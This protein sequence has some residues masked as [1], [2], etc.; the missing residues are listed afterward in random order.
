MKKIY[1]ISA[2]ATTVALVG[3]GT[4]LLLTNGAA[5]D[6]AA[7]EHPPQEMVWAASVKPVKL[8]S[9]TPT[10][11]LLGRVVSFTN[12]QLSS[13]LDAAVMHVNAVEGQ[14]VEQ[15]ETLIELDPRNIETAIA[16]LQADADRVEALLK[17][18]RIKL[19]TNREA[20]IYATNLMHLATESR[21]RIALLRQRN[22]ADLAVFS[23]ALIDE[24]NAKLAVT[25]RKALIREHGSHVARLQADLRHISVSLRNAEADLEESIIKAPIAGR[26]TAVH[27]A[28]GEQVRNGSPILDMFDHQA[29]EIRSLIPTRHLADVKSRIS[30]TEKPEAYAF[31]DNRRLALKLDRLSASVEQGRGGVEAFFQIEDSSFYPELGRTV[32]VSLLQSPVDNA[33]AIPSQT[34]YGAD[35]VFKL[36]DGRLKSVPISRHGEIFRNGEWLVIAVSDQLQA[37]DLIITSRLDNPVDGGKVDIAASAD[38]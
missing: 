24:E 17:D 27:V 29:V 19:A 32:E 3:I 36:V 18:E 15:G 22:L 35:R 30:V 10:V 20:L 6:V 8:E 7:V 33:V 34:I 5:T 1:A 28:E 26:V 16:Q 11:K 23:Q 37:G 25:E 38:L 14:Y 13:I 9:L 31:V 2:V 4:Y 12:L 21:Q